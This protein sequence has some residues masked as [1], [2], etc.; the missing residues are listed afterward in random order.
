MTI[1]R[2]EYP[3]VFR[4]LQLLDFAIGPINDWGNIK[5]EYQLPNYILPEMLDCCEA[6]LP[7]LKQDELNSLCSG[8]R[9]KTTILLE[10]KPWLNLTAFVISAHLSSETKAEKEN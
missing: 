3:M 5:E 6:D 8:D 4:V 1:T 10:A 7:A 9:L 2:A